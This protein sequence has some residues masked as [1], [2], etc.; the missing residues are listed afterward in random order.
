MKF[1]KTII[2]AVL[3]GRDAYVAY[4]MKHSGVMK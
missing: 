4:K 2:N 3:E 1:L